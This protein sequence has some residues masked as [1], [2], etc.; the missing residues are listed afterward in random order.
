MPTLINTVSLRH[1]STFKG[2][3]SGITIDAFAQEGQQSELP[4]IKF[5]AAN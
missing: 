1:V 5:N 4:D 2:P 3:Y